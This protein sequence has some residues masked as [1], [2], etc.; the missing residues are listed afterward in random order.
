MKRKIGMILLVFL[1]GICCSNLF[2]EKNADA[3]AQVKIDTAHFPD[4]VFRSYVKKFDKNKNGYLSKKE[5]NAV[6]TIKLKDDSDERYT[7]LKDASILNL[8]GI[9]YFPNVTELDLHFFKVKNLQFSELKKLKLV[10]LH[11]ITKKDNKKTD[12]E[13]DFTSNKK[14][15]TVYI[16]W[17]KVEEIRFARQAKLKKVMLSQLKKMETISWRLPEL[18]RLLIFSSK[19]LESVDL[20]GCTKLKEIYFASGNIAELNLDR[21]TALEELHVEY[22]NLSALDL[23][24]SRK[25]TRLEC[26][27]NR[28][29]KLDL[30]ANRELTYLDCS[31]NRLKELDLSANRAIEVLVCESNQLKKLDLSASQ[32][33]VYIDCSTN[34][35]EELD[36]SML[37][38]LEKL[39]CAYNRLSSLDISYNKKIAVVNCA[40]NRISSGGISKPPVS[41]AIELDDGGQLLPLGGES[42]TGI[43]I[44]EEHF[45]DYALRYIVL[46]DFDVNHDEILSEEESMQ[47]KKLNLKKYSHGGS[48]VIDCTG[49]EYLKQI[50]DVI[51]SKATE[52]IN[53][54]FSRTGIRM[55][56]TQTKGVFLKSHL[57][58]YC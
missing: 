17:V 50:T 7:L 29:E 53:N 27:F 56:C 18:E 24:D 57:L 35:I 38:K 19:L 34:P 45:P 15:E 9:G 13:F 54:S 8:K 33:L 28:L 55:D 52:L 46:A 21:C 12:N 16:S 32:E 22:N 20:A 14:L 23:S 2:L 1:L 25:L 5:R 51:Y 30:S 4:K 44:D 40:G 47:Q 6:K 42:D 36:V 39:F 41:E 58:Q 49:I 26:S 11:G 43:A 48:P 31:F 3:A 37:Q 10:D